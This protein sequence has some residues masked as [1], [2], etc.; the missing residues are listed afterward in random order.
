MTAIGPLLAATIVTGDL[1]RACAAY[2]AGLG[3][4]RIAEGQIGDQLASLWQTPD[5]SDARWAYLAPGDDSVGGLRLVEAPDPPPK[6]HPLTTFGWGAVELSV[7]E[8][9]RLKGPLED[10]GFR[11]LGAPRP[12]GSNPAI[13]AM[14]VAGPDGEVLYLTDVR[15]YEGSLDIH[16]ATRPVDRAFI[17][18]I[19]CRDLPA[20]RGFYEDRFAVRRVSDHEVDVP[21][22]RDAMNLPDDGRIRISSLQMSGGCLIEH[23]QYPSS[24]S[25]RPTAAGLP[26]GIAM[27]TLRA[28]IADG[29]PINLP[30][31]NGASVQL[32]RGHEGEWIELVGAPP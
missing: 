14:Q 16:R 5:L 28:D 10:A 8:P 4:E 29:T 27:M 17:A 32:R 13:R 21:V 9:E 18:V 15:A 3:M 1:D 26:C 23:D 31:Y 25:E 12:L 19:T 30:P 20:A 11:I 22:L 6:V 7:I 2:S 24:A